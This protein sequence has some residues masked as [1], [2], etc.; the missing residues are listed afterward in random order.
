MARIGQRKP[1]LRRPTGQSGRLASAPGVKAII[2]TMGASENATFNPAWD[3]DPRGRGER[4]E[5]G[6]YQNH[7]S[8]RQQA[9][10]RLQR[11]GDPSGG[12]DR[13]DET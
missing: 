13:L 8:V 2:H 11:A 7:Q 6:V 3:V 9:P 4:A 5:Q 1:I 12:T 10:R